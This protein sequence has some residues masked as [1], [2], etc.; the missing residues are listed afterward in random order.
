VKTQKLLF[1]SLLSLLSIQYANAQKWFP[2]G[3]KWHY[4]GY[5]CDGNPDCAY[6][7]YEIFGDTLV[8]SVTMKQVKID[9]GLEEGDCNSRTE[10]IYEDSNRVFYYD[11]ILNPLYDLN[12]QAGDIFRGLYHDGIYN[13]K[14]NIDSVKIVSIS[15]FNLLQQYITNVDSFQ[16]EMISPITEI[17]GSSVLMLDYSLLGIPEYDGR[18]RCY[19]D[20]SIHYVV[21]EYEGN[22]DRIGV[23]AIIEE[24][25]PISN[26]S[27]FQR[28]E[29]LSITCNVKAIR[30]YHLQI[31]SLE[32]K[33]LKVEV[34]DQSIYH[35]D[36]HTFPSSFIISIIDNKGSP[37]LYRL[38]K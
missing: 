13:L 32:G 20:D 4:T 3:A 15:G 9:C 23:D 10:I 34:V 12:L 27:F 31:I 28:D 37:L 5:S 29:V 17:I 2:I 18:I 24:P 33:M 8:D 14:Y 21:P 6:I 22:C 16:Y 36:T 26:F 25:S 35:L 19:S 11:T 1:L 38:N 7:I 30:G